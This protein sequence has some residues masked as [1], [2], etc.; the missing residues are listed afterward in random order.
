[1]LNDSHSKTTN[2][3]YPYPA[4]LPSFLAQI[5]IYEVEKWDVTVTERKNIFA[6]LIAMSHKLN[7]RNYLPAAY[8]NPSL[9]IVPLRFVWSE[10]NGKIKRDLL[11]KYIDVDGRGFLKPIIATKENLENFGYFDGYCPIRKNR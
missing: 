5:G 6:T 4:R 8:A 11:R 2:N 10:L 9:D 1:M 7:V 3:I